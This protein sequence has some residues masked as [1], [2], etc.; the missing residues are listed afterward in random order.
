M[1][2]SNI[3]N[4]DEFRE[5]VWQ[6]KQDCMEMLVDRCP[7]MD[8]FMRGQYYGEIQG[9]VNVLDCLRSILKY[10]DAE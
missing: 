1:Y 6:E 9:Y 5:W 10:G 4:F 8:N 2:P 3:K 7:E